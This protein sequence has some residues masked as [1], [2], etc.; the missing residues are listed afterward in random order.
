MFASGEQNAEENH[1]M[2]VASK[3]VENV[4]YLRYL[5][6]AVTYR[7]FMLRVINSRLNSRNAG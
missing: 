6:M 7:T 5:L 4:A 3:N 1:N 2:K